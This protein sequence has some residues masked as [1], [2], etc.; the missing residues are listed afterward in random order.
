MVWHYRSCNSM[1]SLGLSQSHN[2]ALHAMVISSP[3]SGF[4]CFLQS[5]SP[6]VFTLFSHPLSRLLPIS[7]LVGKSTLLQ[8]TGHRPDSNHLNHIIISSLSLRPPPQDPLLSCSSTARSPPHPHSPPPSPSGRQV[9]G[10]SPRRA[11]GGPRQPAHREAE[12]RREPHSALLPRVAA[13][14]P[15][16]EAAQGSAHGAGDVER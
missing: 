11:D 15:L 9:Q 6:S 4:S 3:H 16:P 8:C 14:H 1:T 5:G 2:P 13:A 7:L 10:V 12:H